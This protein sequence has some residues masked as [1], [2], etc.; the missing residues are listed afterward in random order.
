[1]DIC[2][3]YLGCVKTFFEGKTPRINFETNNLPSA[4]FRPRFPVFLCR[5]KKGF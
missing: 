2:E 5:S 3:R 1:M 4:A